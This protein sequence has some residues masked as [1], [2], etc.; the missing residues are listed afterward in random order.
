MGTGHPYARVL[1]AA[2]GSVVLAGVFACPAP[3]GDNVQVVPLYSDKGGN[4]AWVE[5]DSAGKRMKATPFVAVGRKELGKVLENPEE[6]KCLALPVPRLMRLVERARQAI[7]DM[8]RP[9]ANSPAGPGDVKAVA[10]APAG[11]AGEPRET[12]PGQTDLS[13]P[14]GKK[15][16]GILP[17]DLLYGTAAR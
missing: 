17:P 1:F 13:A 2:I 12:P 16:A 11:P 3:A 15:D 6:K 4:G 10:A 7:R 9:A 5:I 8:E 14:P